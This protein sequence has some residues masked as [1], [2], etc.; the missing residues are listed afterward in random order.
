MSLSTMSLF[1]TAHFSSLNGLRGFAVLI[2]FFAHL[3]NDDMHLLPLLDFSGIGKSGV[4]LF[5]ILS[6]FL[7]SFQ[8]LN[9]KRGILNRSALGHYCKRRFQRIYPL[10]MLYLLCGLIST[11]VFSNYFNITKHAVPFPL[12][13]HEFLEHLILLDGK[14]V[15]WSIAVEFKFY[16]ILPFIA[17]TITL[18]AKYK[19]LIAFVFILA[20]CIL[21]LLV[22]KGEN[23]VANDSSLFP[24]SLVFLGGILTAFT[25]LFF[26]TNFIKTKINQLFVYLLNI[27]LL[28]CFLISI[29]SIYSIILPDEPIYYF[30]NNL[31]FFSLLWGT[32]IL[33]C[34]NSKNAFYGIFDSKVLAFFGAIS[35]SFYLIHPVIIGIFQF[36]EIDT[37]FNG[38]IILAIT[39][40]I[41]KITYEYIE[42]PCLNIEFPSKNFIFKKTD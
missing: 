9:S 6:S 35:F 39:T 20:L 28:S 4:Y 38:L 19:K 36:F 32:V 18:L 31:L 22:F 34:I 29:P 8:L 23:L 21:S 17:F 7:L 40:L 5:F 15:T 41:S 25:Q 12:S 42:K 1:K 24:Y 30:G 33:F 27:F 16:I 13:F 11:W 2:V 37:L 26:V 10:Y 14:G 3:S